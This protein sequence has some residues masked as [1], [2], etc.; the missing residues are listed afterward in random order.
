MLKAVQADLKKQ[1]SSLPDK[2]VND[3][4]EALASAVRS[5]KS[6]TTETQDFDPKKVSTMSDS[7]FNKFKRE[8][9]F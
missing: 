1:F 5:S 4:R 6:T 9:G 3:D 8:M 7:E 2:S